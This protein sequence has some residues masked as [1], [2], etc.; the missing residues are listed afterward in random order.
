[1]N[2]EGPTHEERMSIR[3]DTALRTIEEMRLPGW[4]AFFRKDAK[5]KKYTDE[6]ES[7]SQRAFRDGDEILFEKASR[8]WVRSWERVNEILAEDYRT[9][10]KDPRNWEIRYIKWMTKITYIKFDSPMGEFYMLPRKPRRKPK[11]ETWY[12]ADEML[13]MLHPGTAATI[14]TFGIFPSRPNSLSGPGANEK[15]LLVNLTGPEMAVRYNL[16]ERRGS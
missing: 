13:V 7:R 4:E 16:G 2:D 3:M 12:T 14:K 8:A 11:V 15:H 5:A 10:N 1:M 9:T 6:Q